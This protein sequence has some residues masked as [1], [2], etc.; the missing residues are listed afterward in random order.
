MP[1]HSS[2]VLDMVSL[3]GLQKTQ[4][5]YISTYSLT[6]WRMESCSEEINNKKSGEN[7]EK[8]YFVV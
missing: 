2:H 8:E 6:K 3:P 5:M 4:M 7:L 1:L